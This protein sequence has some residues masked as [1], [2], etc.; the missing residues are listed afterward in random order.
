MW[1]HT[2]QVSIHSKPSRLY[3]DITG[4]GTPVGDPIECESIR[5]TFAGAQRTNNLFL[6]SVKDNIGHAEA[7]SGVAALIKT[8]LM[9]QNRTIPKQANFASL[10]PSIPPLEQ[11][12][13]VIAERTQTW[14]AARRTAI[15]NNY[16]AA[17]SNAAIVLQEFFPTQVEVVTSEA[18]SNPTEEYEVPL[19][20]SARSPENLR[21]YCMALKSFMETHSDATELNMLADVAYNL[22]I[23]QNR[24]LEYSWTFTSQNIRNFSNQLEASVTE[25]LSF[26]RSIGAK[27]P[28]VLCFG[29]QTGRFVSLSRELYNNCRILQLHLVRPLLNPSLLILILSHGFYCRFGSTSSMS[30]SDIVYMRRLTTS[31]QVECDSACKTLGLPSI[32]PGI[33]QSEAVQDIVELHCRLFCL[34]YSCA[35]CWLDCGLEVD[36]LIGHS[37]GQLTALSVAGSLS[38]LDG[39]RL[40]SARARLIQQRWGPETGIMLAIEGDGP[41]V[42]T[43][44]DSVRQQHVNCSAE[45]ACYNGPKNTVIAGDRESIEAVETVLT[46]E[47]YGKPL[48]AQRLNNTHAFHS[49]LVES[50][51]PGLE[52]ITE[53]IQFREAAIRVETCS[54]SRTWSNVD[55]VRVVQHSRMPVFFTN[56]VERTAKRLGPSIWVEA[57]SGSPIIAIIRRNLQTASSVGHV[58]QPIEIMNSKP[59]GNLARAFATLWAAGSTAQFWPFH[60]VQKDRYAWVNL[61]PYQFEKTRHWIDYKVPTGIKQEMTDA[62][63]PQTTELMHKLSGDSAQAL[64]SINPTHDVFDLCTK[65]HSVL[66]HNLCPASMY[67]ELAIRAARLLGEPT[68]SSRLPRIQQ[69]EISSPLSL[70]PAGTIFLQLAKDTNCDEEWEFSLFSRTQSD[71]AGPTTHATGFVSLL[72]GGTAETS[73]LFQSLNRLVGNPRCEPIMN[74]ATADGLNGAVVYKNFSRVVDYAT[75]FRGVK[76]VFAK[77]HEA[78]GHVY[79]P[80]NQPAELDPGCCDPVAIDNFLQV[81]GIHV[82]CLWNCQDDQVFVCT[83]IRELSFSEQFI[84]K[85]PE[86]RAWTVYSNFEPDSSS[87][88]ANDIFVLESDS[89]QLVVTLMGAKFT[90]VPLKSLSRTLSKLN[91]GSQYGTFD[92]AKTQAAE[93]PAVKE[94]YEHPNE[95]RT[96]I[97]RNHFSLDD[98]PQVVEPHLDEVL[99]KLQVMLNE[100][101][102]ISIEDIKPDSAL[103]DLGIDSLMV[104]E[105]IGEIKSRFGIAISNA[106]FRDLTDLDSLSRRLQPTTPTQRSDQIRRSRVDQS[107]SHNDIPNRVHTASTQDPVGYNNQLSQDLAFTGPDCFARTKWAFDAAA[108]ETTFIGFSK[109]VH[110]IQAQLVLAYVLETF[111]DLGCQLASL[112]P[113]QRLPDIHYSSKHQKVVGQLYK[114]LEDAN[115]ITRSSQGFYRTSVPVPQVSVDILHASIIEKFP[116]HASEHRLLH[117]TGSRL[118]EC[119]TER[120]DPIALLFG[121]PT[122]RALM[123]DVYTNAPMFKAG[124]ILLG[125]YLADILD[126]SESDREI[127]ILELGAGTGGTTSILIELLAN[128]TQKFRYTFTDLSS[129]LVVAAKKKFGQHG[130]M[131]YETL[132]IEQ[133]PVSQHLSR[134]DIIISTN[135]I[136]ATKNLRESTTNVRKM[137]CPNGILCLVE[138][139]QNLFWFDLVF[140]LLEGWW[141]FNDGRKHVLAN[142]RLWEQSLR[143]AGFHWVDWTEGNSEESQIL[144]M[145]TASPSKGLTPSRQDT[146]ERGSINRLETQETVVFAQEGE[147]QLFADI[148]YPKAPDRENV[149]RPIGEAM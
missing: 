97:G 100:L 107:P 49:R 135:C 112:G 59:Q 125:R 61:P 18:N 13:M 32:F 89:G 23:K 34:Q 25:T 31:L 130:F 63:P 67:S 131:V 48:K 148:N 134:Y 66:H 83:A 96:P 53:S 102:E 33:F 94:D 45:I 41:E 117:T 44:L 99:K 93:S 106:D 11:D 54:P 8:I 12:H 79:V 132:D 84:N 90:K 62:S 111:R 68:S 60:Q 29:G 129:S 137:L 146:F 30:F 147:T 42:E 16:G 143:Q 24:S 58:F 139:T 103:D 22:S 70:G 136:H 113:A 15:I 72:A 87:Q 81:S 123:T 85:P 20:V 51:L 19:F 115:I 9:M 36:T 109:H 56:A 88:V 43:L 73:S 104:T 82:N 118:A 127:Q 119:L 138:L 71:I 121:N 142:E 65:G 50:I 38:L 28:V 80:E 37:F 7:A 86:K 40:I 108:H 57:G 149:T 3:F 39:I 128:H 77:D 5:Q 140:G 91:D 46:S 120:A 114:V 35:R 78:V 95:A 10:N 145:I 55:A 64:F 92:N 122:A 21:T 76:R 75:Y 98:L 105:V 144:R 27:R 74:A 17:G 101:L 133:T 6:G 2:A 116:Q 141:L 69:L 26:D 14:L 1:R 126:R 124:T 47:K 4:V 52:E 110:P